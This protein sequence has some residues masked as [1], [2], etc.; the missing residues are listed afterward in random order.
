M[1]ESA[2]STPEMVSRRILMV[3]SYGK[4]LK[5]SWDKDSRPKPVMKFI[6]LSSKLKSNNYLLKND[7]FIL[8]NNN[9]V[10]QMPFY[11]ANK[12]SSFNRLAHFL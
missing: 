3:K 1:L 12:H 4:F 7:C 11:S 2:L 9:A 6:K 10:L 8:M 5:R